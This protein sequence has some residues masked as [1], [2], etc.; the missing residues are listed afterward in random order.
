MI[1]KKI[2]KS[3]NLNELLV[4]I[5]IRGEAKVNFKVDETLNRLRLRRKY[6][7][8]LVKKTPDILGMINKINFSI[9]YGNINQE[10]LSKLLKMRGTKLDKKEFDSEKVAKELLDGK[11]LKE[12]GF[13][14][15][16]RLHPPRKGIKSKLHYPRGVLGNHKENINKLIERML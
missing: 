12:L 4:L 11:T 8:T 15:F 16:F 7:C 10:T 5:R 13:K 3:E 1:E 9:A 2:K 14:P 6:S